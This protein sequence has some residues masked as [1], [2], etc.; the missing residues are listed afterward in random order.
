M[1]SL[2]PS[3]VEVDEP[4]RLRAI[5][6]RLPG[7]MLRERLEMAS[8]CYGPLHTWPEIR[9]KVAETLPRRMGFVRSAVVEPIETYREGIPDEALL[10]YDDAVR[11]GLFSRFWVATPRYYEQRQVDPWIIGEVNGSEQCAV[12]AQWDL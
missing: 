1:D 9:Q 5:R 10:K 11:S 4:A 7:Q 2:T 3:P 6:S 8:V 12:I